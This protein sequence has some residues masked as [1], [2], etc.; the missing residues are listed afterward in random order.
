MALKRGRASRISFTLNRVMPAIDF[1][2]EP[3]FRTAEVDDERSDRM[4]APELRCAGLPITKPPPELE[5]DVSLITSKTPGVWS[6]RFSDLTPHPA[7]SPE[8]RGFD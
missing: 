4:L 5:L 2:D 3:C 6:R 8:G 1:D 7:L